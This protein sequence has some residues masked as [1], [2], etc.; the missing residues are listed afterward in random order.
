MM[1]VLSLI[2]NYRALLLLLVLQLVCCSTPEQRI[3]NKPKSYTVQIKQMQFMP[4]ELT[5]HEGDT[6]KFVNE[7]M[8]AH[9][10]TEETSKAW[11]SGVMQPG[12]SWQL[13]PT[14]DA[15]YFC[16]IHVVMKGKIIMA[17]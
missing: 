12:T 4:A 16:S 3:V 13:I 15:N 8:V 2:L 11:T 10:V 17:K 6:V 5:V 9:D 1:K 14:D 7:D